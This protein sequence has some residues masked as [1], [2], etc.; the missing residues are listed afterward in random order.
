MAASEGEAL[1]SSPNINAE[2]SKKMLDDTNQPIQGNAHG[3]PIG[4]KL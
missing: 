4:Q 3:S 2:M 1:N